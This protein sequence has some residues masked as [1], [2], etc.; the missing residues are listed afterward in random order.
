M[1]KLDIFKQSSLIFLTGKS[2]SGKTYLVKY[3]ITNALL[4]KQL[5]F[6]IVFSL[7]GKY[8]NDYNMLNSNCIIEGYNRQILINYLDMLKQ[9][10]KKYGKLPPPNFIIF[11]DVISSVSNDK[12]FKELISTFRHYSAFIICCTQYPN[13]ISCLT[14]EQ[15]NYAFVFKQQTYRAK[16]G[17]YKAIGDDFETLKDFSSMLDSKTDE[18]YSCLLYNANGDGVDNRY[19]KYKCPVLKKHVKFNF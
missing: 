5:Y 10:R 11:D 4:K 6:G 19:M 12:L 8:N 17:L 14:R 1:K 15:I 3:L 7:T 13:M 2:R 16:D 9:Y 18:Q